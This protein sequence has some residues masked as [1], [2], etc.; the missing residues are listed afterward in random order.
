MSEE[1]VR[2][3]L[4]RLDKYLEALVACYKKAIQQS[5]ATD[6]LGILFASVLKIRSSAQA[7]QLLA[8][9]GFVE[10]ISAIARTMV[11]I[12]INSAYL[13]VAEDEE[14]TRYRLFDTQSMWKHA[15]NLQPQLTTPNLPPRVQELEQIVTETREQTGREDK[16]ATWSIRPLRARAE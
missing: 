16:A 4:R 12:T 13:Q 7:V 6:R 8:E 5:S 11:E 1:E 10:E 9:A 14:V 2:R 3:E 15:Q